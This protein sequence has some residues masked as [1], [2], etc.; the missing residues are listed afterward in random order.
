ME[1]LGIVW[2]HNKGMREWIFKLNCFLCYFRVTAIINDCG[3]NRNKFSGPNSR[4]NR[5]R[6][7]RAKLISVFCLNNV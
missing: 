4:L 7:F 1:E 6:F 2:G 5:L 3:W